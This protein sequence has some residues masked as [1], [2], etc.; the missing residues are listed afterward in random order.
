MLEAHL[1]PPQVAEWELGHPVWVSLTTIGAASNPVRFAGL[2]LATK[3]AERLSPTVPD[4]R[5]PLGVSPPP[6]ARVMRI[7]FDSNVFVIDRSRCAVQLARCQI[8]N[9]IALCMGNKYV[10]CKKRSRPLVV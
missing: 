2:T 8:H 3:L 9:D 4:A 1:V 5:I 10:F 7:R 6:S